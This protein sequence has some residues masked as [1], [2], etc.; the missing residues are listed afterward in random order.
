[1]GPL[2]YRLGLR[3]RRVRRVR[4]VSLATYHFLTSHSNTGTPA[5]AAI[6]TGQR[7]WKH[8]MLGYGAVAQK[9][10]F[11]FPR[12]LRDMGGYR[13]VTV[14][15]DHFGWNT[16]SNN[17]I[18]HGY[19]NL[20][21]YDGLGSWNSTK[22]IVTGEFDQYTQWFERE[23]PGQDPLATL[24]NKLNL[25]ESWNT[26][27]GSSYIYDE[28]VHPTR[29]VGDQALAFL[30][31]DD[32]KE[33]PFLL[34][35][36]FHRPHSPYDPPERLLAQIEAEDL[37]SKVICANETSPADDTG[38]GD[39]WCVR[40][41]GK[42][43]DDPIGCG[44]SDPN[45]WCGLMPLSNETLSRR[46]YAASV[47]FVDEQIGRIMHV[48]KERNLLENTFVFFT[49]DHGDGQ[50]THH[51]W[52]KGYP[53]EF[54]AHVPLVMRWPESYDSKIPRGTAIRA[55][56]VT[57]LRDLFHTFIDVANL[58]ESLSAVLPSNHFDANDG[59]SLLCLLQD[60]SGLEH[61]SYEINPGPWREW[62]D[63]E[64][65]T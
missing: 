38:H 40:F 55:P 37:P 19:S 58:T 65:S 41:R 14:G 35:V 11:E 54:S 50:G 34:K 4:Y 33:K 1:M 64:H 51:H 39:S 7:P 2:F 28:R 62:I 61:C 43:N 18:S 21:L 20:T 25:T 46:A 56:V 26:W 53:Y 36:S 44:S 48:L 17:G 45:A 23:L 31:R 12:I 3:R 10:P 52:R 29:W 13:T 49:S 60:S 27:Y 59:K 47:R 6:L 9:Y 8:G 22:K 16:T 32:V 57:E 42:E 30:Q 24:D 15:K 5:R 63:M